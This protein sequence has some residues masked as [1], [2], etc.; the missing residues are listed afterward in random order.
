MRGLL[1]PAGGKIATA[2]AETH[3]IAH[4]A[5]AAQGLEQVKDFFPF[6]EGIH[7]RRAQRA[8]VLQEKSG[9]AGV[10]EQAGQ[11]ADDHADVFRALRHRQTGQLFHAQDVGPVVGHRTDVIQPV[12]VRDGGEVTVFLGDFFVVAMEVT[13]N[14]SQFDHGFAVKNNVHAENAVGGGMVRPH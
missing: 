13:E 8:H 11:F 10:V 14:G 1:Q 7:Q 9:Q 6:A 2:A 4:H 12:G 3:V 5:R